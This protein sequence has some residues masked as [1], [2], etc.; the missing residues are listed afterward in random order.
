MMATGLGL[1][2]HARTIHQDTE[3][4]IPAVAHVHTTR[5]LGYLVSTVRSTSFGPT[6][7][8]APRCPSHS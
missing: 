2:S 6:A 1:D 5:G 3:S 8:S 7:P 4:R